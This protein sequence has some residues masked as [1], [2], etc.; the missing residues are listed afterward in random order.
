LFKSIGVQKR[1][2]RRDFHHVSDDLTLTQA[3][4]PFHQ[5]NSCSGE[6]LAVLVRLAVLVLVRMMDDAQTA[7]GPH[8]ACKKLIHRRLYGE[9]SRACALRFLA[10]WTKV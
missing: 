1:E 2:N 5:P 9:Q 6:S 8:S 4:E 3:A 7:T 10:G